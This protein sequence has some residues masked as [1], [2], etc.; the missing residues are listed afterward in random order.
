MAETELQVLDLSRSPQG[1]NNLERETDLGL[2]LLRDSVNLDISNT[3][4]K[5]R[6]LGYTKIYSGTNVHSLFE[7]YF[8]ENGSLKRLNSDN[9]ATTLVSG[10]SVYPKMYYQRIE[11][12]V[13]YSNGVE[14]G[15]L[16]DDV[17]ESWGVPNPS[18]SP[19]FTIRGGISIQA[20]YM[21]KL[22]NVRSG[23][24]SGASEAIIIDLNENQGIT[25]S[26][27]PQDSG[28][29]YVRVYMTL[30][31]G[32]NFY[33]QRDIPIGITTYNLPEPE[34]GAEL[35]TDNLYSQPA[36]INLQLYNGRIYYSSDDKLFYT[37]PLRYGLYHYNNF[38]RF[39]GTIKLVLAVNN[40]LYVIADKTYFLDGQGPETFKQSTVLNDSGIIGT[41]IVLHHSYFNIKDYSGLVAAWYSDKGLVLGL[42]NGNI[43]IITEKRFAMDNYSH[44]ATGYIENQGIRK[45]I[46]SFT[47]KGTENK[48]Q[49][50]DVIIPTVIRGVSFIDNLNISD[51]VQATIVPA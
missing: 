8:M 36:G 4:K 5:R 13:Y 46:T 23:E 18:V 35:Q 7:N 16:R 44:G 21:V 10:L 39:P 31:N 34:L 22:V 14:S 24:E 1:I 28:V 49:S 32:Q 48:F 29:D 27:I 2:E 30:P 11:N 3:G 43:N 12:M 38:F 45:L 6:R 33:R 37:E 42:N 47:N 51:S 40:G 41:G 20:T 25:L 9:T 50:T 26:N 15:C 19:S 17:N